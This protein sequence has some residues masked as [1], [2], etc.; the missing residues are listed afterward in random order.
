[1][2]WLFLAAVSAAPLPTI[3]D[4]LKSGAEAPHDAAVLIGLESYFAMPA[5][6][7]AER[8]AKAF[9]DY[10]I[11]THGIPSDRVRSVPMANREKILGAIEQAAELAGDAG[12]VWVY[13]AGHGGASPTTGERLLMGVDVQPDLESFEARSVSV[14]TVKETALANGSK[15]ILVLDTCYTGQGRSGAD[16][17]PG[18]RFAVP[19][20]AAAPS[21]RVLEWSAASANQFSGPLEDAE[22][23]GSATSI[24]GDV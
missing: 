4:P 7:Y 20:Y 14:E 6:P 5:V 16:L 2:I 10:L 24:S 17:I 8:D 13:F 3:D 23:G 19:A 9:A 1:M 22:H 18:R 21:P 11:Y 15:V 12:T